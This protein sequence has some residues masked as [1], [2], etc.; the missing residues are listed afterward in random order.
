[1]LRPVGDVD[2]RWYWGVGP[3]TWA[4]DAGLKSNFGAQ[5]EAAASGVWFVPVA[6]A[7]DAEDAMINRLQF[8]ARATDIEARLRQ[9]SRRDVR[10]LETHIC[11]KGLT[12]SI[13]SAATFTVQAETMCGLGRSPAPEELRAELLKLKTA[14]H[15]AVVALERETSALVKESMDRYDSTEIKPTRRLQIR[16]PRPRLVRGVA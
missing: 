2:L 9:L 4:G 10:I 7:S 12:F 16:D 14:K 6:D 15:P 1:M 13:S 5:L 8:A 11:G 3:D